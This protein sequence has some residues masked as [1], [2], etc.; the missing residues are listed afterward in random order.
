MPMLSNTFDKF[1]RIGLFRATTQTVCTR[2][3]RARVASS[4][5]A[6]TTPVQVTTMPPRQSQR[7]TQRERGDSQSQVLSSQASQ[8]QG[9][10][11]L[12]C[13]P[14]KHDVIREAQ[15]ISAPRLTKLKEVC[16]AFTCEDA[17]FD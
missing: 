17:R 6:E 10:S 8:S 9:P 15:I 14:D 7:A 1:N 3:V 16:F 11:T 13:G 5:A 12:A 2:A 4:S